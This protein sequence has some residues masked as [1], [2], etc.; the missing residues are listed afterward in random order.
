MADAVSDLR[1]ISNGRLKDYWPYTVRDHA[2]YK[3][4]GLNGRV[5]DGRGD[6]FIGL[7]DI[8]GAAKDELDSRQM[9]VD[10]GQ[11]FTLAPRTKLSAKAGFT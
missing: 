10:A 6:G 7:N 3:G 4:F 2:D 9:L 8:F 1:L 5:R 11:T